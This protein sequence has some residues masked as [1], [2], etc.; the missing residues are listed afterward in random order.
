[1]TKTMVKKRYLLWFLNNNFA[2]QLDLQNSN[3]LEIVP[4]EKLGF[5][6]IADVFI[7]RRA[8]NLSNALRKIQ[9][10]N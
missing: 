1:M 5:L 8:F 2:I 7:H 9:K 3:I 6:S 4:S 10:I